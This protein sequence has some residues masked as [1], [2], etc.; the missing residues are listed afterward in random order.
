[1]LAMKATSLGELV[2]LYLL[3]CEAEGKSAQTVRAYGETLG[4]F[5]RALAVDEAPAVSPE[6]VYRYLSTFKHL[7]LDTRHRYFR[8]VRCFFN[9]LVEASYLPDSPFRGIRNVRLPHRIVEPFTPADIGRLLA[10]CDADSALGMRD[11][12]MVLSLLD[13]GVRCSELVHLS[14]DDLDL[15]AR[16]LRVRHGKGNK[17]RVV[18]FAEACRAAL[19]CY[20]ETRGAEPG[21]LFW[22]PA[23]SVCSRRMSG[24][25]RTASS[26]CCADSG[27]VQAW[28]RCT[29]IASATRSRTGPS[30]TTLASSTCST[31]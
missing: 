16:R 28:R 21:P 19:S 4:R 30:H 25:N 1:M 20:L 11:R 24:S 27:G 7:S 17:Q 9:W 29:R 26:R 5:R 12:A 18:A 14:I 3:R 31:C 6:H 22:P 13:T 23:T 15:E 2:A 8:E 10:A